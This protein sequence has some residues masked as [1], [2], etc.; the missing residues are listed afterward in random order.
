MRKLYSHH[1][2]QT[3]LSLLRQIRLDADLRQ[4]DVAA[5][6]RRRQTF[7]SKYETGERRLDILELRAVCSACDTTLSEFI[8]RLESL[9]P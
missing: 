1:T 5:R 8:Y 7:V 3:L 2:Q 9:L 6:L 4:E